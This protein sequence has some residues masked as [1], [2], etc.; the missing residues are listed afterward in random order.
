MATEQWI[1]SL[2][3]VPLSSG[4]PCWPWVENVTSNW[5]LMFRCLNRG[6][7]IPATL[8]KSTKLNLR[9]CVFGRWKLLWGKREIFQVQNFPWYSSSDQRIG[10]CVQRPRIYM[11]N[12]SH[13]GGGKK[14]SNQLTRSLTT[15]EIPWNTSREG[16]ALVIGHKSSGRQSRLK[17]LSKPACRSY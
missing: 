10:E 14:Q 1:Y 4:M 12:I 2:S 13:L 5:R 11:L 7:K 17:V 16:M 15:T 3:L 9:S 8:I 6:R